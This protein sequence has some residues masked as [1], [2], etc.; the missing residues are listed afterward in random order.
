MFIRIFRYDAELQQESA[1]Q[2]S[3]LYARLSTASP[4]IFLNSSTMTNNGK[5]E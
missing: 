2:L 1:F 4:E 3:M 5:K